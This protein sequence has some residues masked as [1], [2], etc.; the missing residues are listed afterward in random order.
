[1]RD[2]DQ[3]VATIDAYFKVLEHRLTMKRSVQECQIIFGNKSLLFVDLVAMKSLLIILVAILFTVIQVNCWTR[4]PNH[5]SSAKLYSKSRN[6]RIVKSHTFSALSDKQQQH[7]NSDISLK[8]PSTSMLST[9]KSI[10]NFTRPHTIIGS[11]ISVISLYLFA[12]PSKHWHEPRFLKSI[13]ATLIPSLFMNLYI[14]GLNQVTD[15][16]IDRINK[17][18]LP[19]ASGKLSKTTGIW[20]VLASL[21]MSLVNYKNMEWP[22][23]LTLLGSAFL[24]TIYSLPPFRLKRFPLLAAL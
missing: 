5:I 21:A 16:E 20:I 8:E 3:W 14:T 17:P 7:F 19:L 9:A 11:C 22:L 23:Q 12:I 6:G 1:M 2:L 4:I 18:Y 13:F 24:G 10:W 15:I